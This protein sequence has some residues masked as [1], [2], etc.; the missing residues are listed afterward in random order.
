MMRQ[1]EAALT[2]TMRIR[3]KPPLMAR[4]YVLI[5]ALL[6]AWNTSAF[7]VNSSVSHK[8]PAPP[9]PTLWT[10]RRFVILAENN[11]D[12]A[13][14]S[15]ETIPPG[16]P[17]NV[18]GYALAFVAFWPLLALLRVW[19]QDQVDVD[20]FMAIKGML[21]NS[22][23]P[24]MNEIRELPPLSPAEQIVGALFGPPSR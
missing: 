14:E 20:S 24:D 10:R 6:C 13:D 16:L 3:K 17:L 19:S 1:L 12:D 11:N 5:F 21:D 22:S 7:V 2:I 9:F 8:R 18:V 23:V 4:P 15:S